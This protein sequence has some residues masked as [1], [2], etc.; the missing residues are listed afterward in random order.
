MKE[1]NPNYLSLATSICEVEAILNSRLLTKISDEPRDVLALAPN[2]LLFL[3][4]GPEVFQ[5]I[6]FKRRDQ[7]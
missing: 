6:L 4:A 5:W 3:R 7:Y 2:H 1:Q